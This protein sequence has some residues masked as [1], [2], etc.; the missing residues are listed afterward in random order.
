MNFSINSNM[1]AMEQIGH[2]YEWNYLFA[3]LLILVGGLFNVLIC[4]AV[5]FKRKLQSDK[6]Y[7]LLSLAV[8]DLLVNFLVMPLRITQAVV[9]EFSAID[10]RTLNIELFLKIIF[11]TDLLVK[12]VTGLSEQ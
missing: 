6:N 4:L 5:L 8:A 7:F 12:Q 11:W 1:D 9:G 3:V 2:Q 10:S